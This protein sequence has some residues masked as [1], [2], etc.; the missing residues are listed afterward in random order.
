MFR[1]VDGSKLVCLKSRDSSISRRLVRLKD[2]SHGK[3]P[4]PDISDKTPI[5]ASS[6]SKTSILT[7]NAASGSV[8]LTPTNTKS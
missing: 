8:N 4:Y 5:N 7:V 6:V 3:R 2:M 1:D